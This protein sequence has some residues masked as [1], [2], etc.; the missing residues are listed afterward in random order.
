MGEAVV[1]ESVAEVETVFG[2]SGVAVKG[3]VVG[4][5]VEE[6]DSEVAERD[7]TG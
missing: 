3:V 5:H 6:A 4:T 2:E 1:T 7:N